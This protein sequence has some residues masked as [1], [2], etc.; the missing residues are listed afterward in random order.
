MASPWF[1]PEQNNNRTVEDG[2]PNN[3][4]NDHINCGFHSARVNIN[5]VA[6]DILVRKHACA[7]VGG[8]EERDR[9]SAGVPGTWRECGLPIK[10]AKRFFSGR[11]DGS[12]GVVNL[13]AT[14][15]LRHSAWL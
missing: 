13:G 1:S 12:H 2:R 14:R 10:W 3:V 11:G 7:L 15:R 8:G 9:F 5:P 6:L 4:Q